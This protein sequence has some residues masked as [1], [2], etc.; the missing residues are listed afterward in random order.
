MTTLL[1]P[2]HPPTTELAAAWESQS[3]QIPI[4]D[5]G[6][7]VVPNDKP[8]RFPDAPNLEH[9]GLAKLRQWDA[10]CKAANSRN[11]SALAASKSTFEKGRPA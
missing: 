4:G 8:V 9:P 5:T 6:H 1:S 11:A 10:E 3:S 2:F 7:W